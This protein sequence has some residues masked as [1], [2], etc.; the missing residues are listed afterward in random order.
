MNLIS[1]LLS[2]DDP[3]A[4]ILDV[5]NVVGSVTAYARDHLRLPL[6]WLSWVIDLPATTANPVQP[7]RCVP[8]CFS[9]PHC[10]RTVGGR[11]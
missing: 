10:I 11:V 4:S 1:P 5:C 7:E 2:Q 8:S 6:P 9:I 3:K